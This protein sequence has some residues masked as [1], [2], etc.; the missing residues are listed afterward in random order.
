[1]S[2]GAV[3]SHPL[4]SSAE[5]MGEGLLL[6]VFACMYVYNRLFLGIIARSQTLPPATHAATPWNQN[7]ASRKYPLTTRAPKLQLA[8]GQQSSFS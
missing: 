7:H 8:A 1:M 4:R 6:F 3:L 5:S 2:P